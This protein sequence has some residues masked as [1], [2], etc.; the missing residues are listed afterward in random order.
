MAKFTYLVTVE[1]SDESITAPERYVDEASWIDDK[2]DLVTPYLV[3][4][5]MA[6]IVMSERL[7]CE[8]DY[9]FDYTVDYEDYGTF[10]LQLTE[11]GKLGGAR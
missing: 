9:G 6:D 11:Q 5:Q 4:E 1:V 8:D 10:L 3:S 2:G 7:S